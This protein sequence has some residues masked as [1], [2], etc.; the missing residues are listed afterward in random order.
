MNNVFL[1]EQ[2]KCQ[3]VVSPLSINIKGYCV[4]NS[5]SKDE[6]RLKEKIHF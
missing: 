1:I 5:F 6:K 3:E 2:L 4:I